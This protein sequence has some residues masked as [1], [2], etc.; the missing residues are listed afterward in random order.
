MGKFGHPVC[1]GSRRPQVRIL[2]GRLSGRSGF[3]SRSSSRASRPGGGVTAARPRLRLK[4][5]WLSTGLPSRGTG[6]E[7][8][9]ALNTTFAGADL[10]LVAREGRVGTDRWLHASEAPVGERRPRK[11]EQVG[12]TPTTGSLAAEA[13]YGRA[14]TWYVGGRGFNSHSWLCVV[15]AQLAERDL[16]KVEAAGS[17]PVHHSMRLKLR[18]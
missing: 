16:A 12:S 17:S 8:L 1:F 6:F 3:E 13:Q 14:P 11:T 7:S 2:V 15:V 18:W 4:L 10:A 5:N 9:Q